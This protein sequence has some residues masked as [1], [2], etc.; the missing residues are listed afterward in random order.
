MKKSY[1]FTLKIILFELYMVINELQ[2]TTKDSN[3]RETQRY[4]GK[5]LTTKE[6][7]INKLTLK[8]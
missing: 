6:V 8:K 5:D 1:E 7:F 2:K 3:G 4:R